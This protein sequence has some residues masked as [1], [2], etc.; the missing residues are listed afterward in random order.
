MS[1]DQIVDLDSCGA[2]TK[3]G[4]PCRNPAPSKGA[5][6]AG[7]HT[8]VNYNRARITQSTLKSRGWTQAMIRDVLGD[9]DRTAPNPHYSKGA[10]MKL[11]LLEDVEAAE[12]SDE[13]AAAKTKADKRRESS[14]KGLEAAATAKAVREVMHEAS[15]KSAW[16]SHVEEYAQR[17]AEDA[18]SLDPSITKPERELS[19]RDAN[20]F[21][22]RFGYR[23]C[24]VCGWAHEKSAKCLPS[25][26]EVMQQASVATMVNQV[27]V[28]NPQLAQSFIDSAY[29]TDDIRP[30]RWTPDQTPDHF[31]TNET[32]RRLGVTTKTVKKELGE[33]D[34]V[35]QSAD[36]VV[37]LYSKQR[38]FDYLTDRDDK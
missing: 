24:P 25:I 22:E 21:L 4:E 3:S 30:K 1:S 31:S 32:A 17:A 18:L 10:P 8:P 23:V 6:C 13:F 14:R 36:T 2:A 12:R 5:K 19:Q 38:V 9:P 28:G 15:D 34:K 33:P 7:G 11:W 27:F 26:T 20:R 37:K 29:K 35:F 16:E